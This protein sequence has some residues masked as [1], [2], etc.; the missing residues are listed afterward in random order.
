MGPEAYLAKFMQW[1]H[2][3]WIAQNL[4]TNHERRKLSEL[5]VIQCLPRSDCLEFLCRMRQLVVSTMMSIVLEASEGT[6]NWSVC[7]SSELE[8]CPVFPYKCCRVGWRTRQGMHDF[9]TYLSHKDL[10]SYLACCTSQ[11]SFTS[12]WPQSRC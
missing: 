3:T 12:L 9:L 7:K 4:H 11:D 6:A 8:V 10:A 2:N 1:V 5:E